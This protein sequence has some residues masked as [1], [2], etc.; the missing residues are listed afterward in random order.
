MK[1]KAIIFLLILPLVISILAFVSSSFFIRGVEQDITAI[2]WNYKANEGFLISEGKVKLEAN[3]IYD[4]RYPLSEGN[5]LVWTLNNNNYCK[6][7]II[8]GETYLVPLSP[9]S[10]I[11]TCQNEKQTITQSFTAV[12]IGDEGAIILNPIIP[13]SKN[14]ISSTNY[15]GLYESTT[16][17]DNNKIDTTLKL[18]VEVIG[19][20]SSIAT[21]SVDH[22]DNI[23]FNVNEK[24]ITF[25]KEGEAYIRLYRSYSSKGE[26]YLN[27][28]IVKAVNIYNYE[29]L[30]NVTNKT[31]KKY[32]AVLRVNL[33]SFDNTYFVSKDNTLT[34]KSNDTELFGQL[35]ENNKV[36]SFIDDLYIFETTYNHDFLN[37]WNEAVKNNLI[38]NAY[39]TPIIRYAGVHIQADFY[40]NGFRINTHELVYPSLTQS[41]NV[42]G[43]TIVVPLLSDEDLYR[44][45][46]AFV[47]MGDPNYIFD[48]KI[49]KPIFTIFGQDNSSFYINDDNVTVDNVH[50]KGC[51]FGNNLTNLQYTGSTLDINANNVVIQ[52]SILENNR[53]IIRSYSSKNLLV[54]NCLLRNS[55]EFLFRSGSN[56]F[57]KVNYDENVRYLGEN[58]VSYITSKSNYLSK[59]IFTDN[60]LDD[61]SKS[62]RADSLLTNSAVVNTQ[63]NEFL[64]TPLQGYTKEEFIIGQQTIREALTNLEGIYDKNNK[65]VYAGNT[66]I[67]DT[68]FQNSGISAISMDTLY[69]GPF[70]ETNITSLFIFLLG[71]YTSFLPK[72]LALTS[73]PTLLTLSGDIRFYDW[74]NKN[75]LYF[76]SLVDEDIAGLI[77]AH[78]GLG[79]SFEVNISE[80]DYLP[81]KKILLDNYS[82]DVLSN[83][84]LNIPIYFQGGGYNASEVII[85]EELKS[86]FNSIRYDIDPFVYS[87]DLKQT[88]STHFMSDPQAKYEAMKIAMLR[89]ASNFMGLYSYKLLTLNNEVSKWIGETPNINDLISRA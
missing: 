32:P 13:F 45:P 72:N 12:I 40:G 85:D 53:N 78:G 23:D 18:E 25:L 9:G 31:N 22:S 34:K 14:S 69:Q 68:Y 42:D 4:E 16:S 80:D 15:V 70:L 24:E 41:I 59:Q 8:N 44:G 28:N 30:M 75:N 63:A 48:Q 52:N 87:L 6:L 56:E 3:P 86:Y 47:T 43:N 38:E 76:E 77:I 51:E 5:N 21:L 54:D 35:D 61:I 36:K 62:Y 2:S 11:V 73:Y 49:Q 1:T 29:G 55:M 67:N 58:N 71:I 88:P 17:Y 46:L 79:S 81:I 66:I 27:F 89:A 20:S 7:E 50:F 83:D 10:T 84:Q 33:E 74:K 64:N 39:E 37:S 19:G 65:K 82:S 26:A 60:G 57:N